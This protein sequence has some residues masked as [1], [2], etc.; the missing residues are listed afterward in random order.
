[1]RCRKVLLLPLLRRGHGHGCDLG[2]V[3]L[4]PL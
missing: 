4:S 3:M 2:G 1:M